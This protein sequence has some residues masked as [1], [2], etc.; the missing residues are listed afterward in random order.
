M[1]HPEFLMTAPVHSFQGF[2]ASATFGGIGPFRTQGNPATSRRLT[3]AVEIY[4]NSQIYV[5]STPEPSNTSLSNQHS[6]GLPPAIQMKVAS[7]KISLGI[8][9]LFSLLS[10]CTLVLPRS[11]SAAEPAVSTS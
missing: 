2:R 11:G 6:A 8:N 3:F 5:R 9:S 1:P 7:L 10:A 4:R